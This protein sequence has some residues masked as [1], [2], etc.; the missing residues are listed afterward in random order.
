MLQGGFLRG[1]VIVVECGTLHPIQLTT[2]TYAEKRM[3][4]VSSSR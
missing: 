3:Q 4:Q 2:A 1:V